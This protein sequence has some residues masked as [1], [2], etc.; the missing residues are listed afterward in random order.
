M[1]DSTVCAQRIT[2]ISNLVI[3]EYSHR[4]KTLYI[5]LY[6]YVYV[7]FKSLRKKISIFL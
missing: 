1:D 2:V 7:V 3:L 5:D 4:V 6:V